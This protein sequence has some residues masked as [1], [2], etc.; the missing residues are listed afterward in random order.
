MHREERSGIVDSKQE[1]YFMREWSMAEGTVIAEGM[2]VIGDLDKN[3][4]REI[5]GVEVQF[6]SELK[7]E[8]LRK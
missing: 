8:Q 6:S 4:F 2:G 5:V 3:N 7:S 1:G